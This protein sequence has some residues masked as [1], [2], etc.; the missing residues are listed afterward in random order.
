MNFKLTGIADL[1]IG[2]WNTY[3]GF[4]DR[5]EENLTYEDST[6]IIHF[7][8]KKA[9]LGAIRFLMLGVGYGLAKNDN[10]MTIDA[11]GI[12]LMAS[13]TAGFIIEGALGMFPGIIESESVNYK[14]YHHHLLK[15]NEIYDNATDRLNLSVG[16]SYQLFMLGNKLA[17]GNLVERVI[18]SL[19]KK[20][21]EYK[22]KFELDDQ[23]RYNSLEKFL[24]NHFKPNEKI[25]N[26]IN[27]FIEG[28]SLKVDTNTI[29]ENHSRLD[30]NENKEFVDY[31]KFSN[32]SK[33][34]YEKDMMVE[35]Q[36]VN[37]EA[38]L[39]TYDFIRKQNIELFF[40]RVV[41]DYSKGIVH[42]S[43]IEDFKLL[44]EK[45]R[46]KK[47][48]KNNR[49]EYFEES[50]QKIEK[51]ATLMLENKPLYGKNVNIKT[52]LSDINPD[53]IKG[54]KIRIYSFDDSFEFFKRNLVAI[55]Y[56]QAKLSKGI[57][58]FIG[59]LNINIRKDK[60]VNV[61]EL[62]HDNESF[63]EIMRLKKEK[64]RSY[65]EVNKLIIAEQS[66]NKLE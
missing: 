5:K 55:K 32:N 54:D 49:P 14:H 21:S 17:T 31:F 47:D 38:I 63:R 33:G 57:Q 30:S 7:N 45:N 20:V 36:K 37:Q 23:S 53:L 27:L 44:H 58:S 50:Y 26:I 11:I 61:N 9:A 13:F 62:E 1:L 4:K 24:V 18:F 22:A 52:I 43:I 42:S 66:K 64:N 3:Q 65:I 28:S 8:S 35:L 56:E 15:K 48:N 41:L 59:N 39:K 6:S 25:S 10:L 46:L 34:R 12:G 19:K 16:T 40:A 51:M 2:S 60:K 29:I